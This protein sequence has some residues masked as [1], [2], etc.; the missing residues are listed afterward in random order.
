[1]C[2]IRFIFIGVTF[3]YINSLWLKISLGKTINHSILSIKIINIIFL[4]FIQI[5]FFCLNFQI[6]QFYIY[7]PNSSVCILIFAIR[8]K[9]FLLILNLV[10]FL[11]NSFHCIIWILH[12]FYYF[13]SIFIS[14]VFLINN[15]LRS[16]HSISFI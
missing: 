16:N 9:Q 6:C 5:S 8:K 10:F 7:I 2:S 15:F 11:F 12:F 3:F 14:S 4:F 1:M 13:L